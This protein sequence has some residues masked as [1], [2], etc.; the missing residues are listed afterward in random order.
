MN[1]KSSHKG[2]WTIYIY[3]QTI[4]ANF[5]S[6]TLAKARIPPMRLR[7]ICLRS[8]HS[9]AGLSWFWGLPMKVRKR[10]CLV[11]KAVGKKLGNKCAVFVAFYLEI[12]LPKENL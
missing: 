11:K 2:F 3:I 7:I 5:L 9:K 10:M 12:L 4:E 1:F 6:G 8:K